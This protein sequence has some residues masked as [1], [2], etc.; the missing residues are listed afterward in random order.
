MKIYRVERY[1]IRTYSREKIT[2]G[3]LGNFTTK[4]KALNAI[5]EWEK[6]YSNSHHIE[7]KENDGNTIGYRI[8][9][10]PYFYEE[11]EFCIYEEEVQ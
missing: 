8:E 3:H 2:A 4:E 5:N 10:A 9:V 11:I 6:K 1:K 7:K